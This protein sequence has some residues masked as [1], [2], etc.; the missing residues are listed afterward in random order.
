MPHVI[1]D[2]C[3]KD[4]LCLAVC[5]TDS[6]HP[7]KDESFDEPSQLFIDPSTCIDCG[8]CIDECPQKAIF[9]ESDAEPKFIETNAAHF[10]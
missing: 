6:I 3:T 10:K 1:T 2:K 7:R 9:A 5:P 4:G 8:V